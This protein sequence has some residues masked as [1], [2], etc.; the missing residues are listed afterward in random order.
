MKG[1]DMSSCTTLEFKLIQLRNSI[2]SYI[3][4]KIKTRKSSSSRLHNVTTPSPLSGAISPPISEPLHH[5][6]TKKCKSA[7]HADS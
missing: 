3:E 1:Q 7:S 4:M 5:S 6:V 2:E